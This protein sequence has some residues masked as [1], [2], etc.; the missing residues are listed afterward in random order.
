MK[1]DVP[2]EQQA[3]IDAAPQTGLVLRIGNRPRKRAP[4]VEVMEWDVIAG[5]HASGR[6]KRA[7]TLIQAEHIGAIQDLSGAEFDPLDLRRNLLVSGINL[8]SLLGARFSVGEVVLEGTLPC[9]PC[10]HME[11][12]L[13]PGGL[14]AMTGMGGL[15]ARVIQ[16]GTIRVGD[17]VRRVVS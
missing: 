3:L 4:V 5:D 9:D 13:G 16:P 11:R 1:L 2:S 15:C 6:Q 7:V 10:E 17:V 8:T 14:A 12:L